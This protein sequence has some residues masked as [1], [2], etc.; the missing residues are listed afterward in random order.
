[1]CS[2]GLVERGTFSLCLYVL[3]GVIFNRKQNLCVTI[4]AGQREG[5][6]RWGACFR[7]KQ[8]AP[9]IFEP[10]RMPTA[11]EANEMIFVLS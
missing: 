6:L 5:D 10:A 8:V 2:G 4:Q 7:R 11:N 1:M 3:A 9:C